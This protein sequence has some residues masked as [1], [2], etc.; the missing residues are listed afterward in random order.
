MKALLKREILLNQSFLWVVL[1]MLPFSYVI[2]VGGVPVVVGVMVGFISG[3]FYYDEK[4]GMDKF[5]VS[6][7]FTRKE[8]INAKY[9]FAI[10]FM[11]FIFVYVLFVDKAAHYFLDYLHHEPFTI[12]SWFMFYLISLIVMAFFFP[13]Y[14]K[15]SFMFAFIFQIFTMMLGPVALSAFVYWLT[16]KTSLWNYIE[17]YVQNI[18]LM[19][20]KNPIPILLA[21]AIVTMV[22][23]WLISQRIFFKKDLS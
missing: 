9:V 2:N 11:F 4:S 18:L 5:V 20:E 21:V 17:D 12:S 3:L 8:V 22:I 19:L 1:L 14:I 6:L 16:K 7:P 23:S 10:L 13:F 15:F